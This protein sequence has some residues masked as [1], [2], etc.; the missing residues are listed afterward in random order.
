MKYNLLEKRWLSSSPWNVTPFQRLI[1]HCA[2]CCKLTRLYI[3]AYVHSK[4]IICKW[5]CM[6]KW[7]FAKW[8]LN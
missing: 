6:R 2:A 3:E 7:Q 8:H 1:F 4:N 5:E